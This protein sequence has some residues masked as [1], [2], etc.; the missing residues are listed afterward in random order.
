MASDHWTGGVKRIGDIDLVIREEQAN[1]ILEL[2]GASAYS[3]S[4]MG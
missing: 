2:L 3:T 1:E 4:E